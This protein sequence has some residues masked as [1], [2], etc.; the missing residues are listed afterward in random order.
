LVEQLPIDS[1][2]GHGVD[3]HLVAFS[4]DEDIDGMEDVVIGDAVTASRWVDLHT[5]ISYYEKIGRQPPIEILDHA[6]PESRTSFV[7]CPIPRDEIDGDARGPYPHA[8]LPDPDAHRKP[9]RWHPCDAAQPGNP[10]AIGCTGTTL[11]LYTWS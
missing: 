3:D 10:Q 6:V 4:H 9:L 8:N 7:A 5:E 1:P 11:V 2:E